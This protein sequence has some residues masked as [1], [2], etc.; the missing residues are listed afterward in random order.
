LKLSLFA[1]VAVLFAVVAVVALSSFVVITASSSNDA[2]ESIPSWNVIDRRRVTDPLLPG[3]CTSTTESGSISFN[4]SISSK[5]YAD[6]NDDD[7]SSNPGGEDVGAATDNNDDDESSN[8]GGGGGDVGA[9][10]AAHVP[11]DAR[12][13]SGPGVYVDVDDP[14]WDN[15]RKGARYCCGC[16]CRC[17]RG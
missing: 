3:N 6:I 10:A 16:G 4:I 13:C 7:E 8:P 9:G 14:C 11:I 2:G 17:C 1:V 12:R 15:R 5:S